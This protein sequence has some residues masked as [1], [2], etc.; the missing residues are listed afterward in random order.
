MR[1]HTYAHTFVQI[2]IQYSKTDGY[3]MTL[4]FALIYK[5]GQV[6]S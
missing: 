6:F 2:K 4:E 1:T 3:Q 5:I